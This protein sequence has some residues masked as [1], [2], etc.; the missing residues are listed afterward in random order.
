MV[1]GPLDCVQVPVPTEAAL[2]AVLATSDAQI[3]WSGPALACSASLMVASLYVEQV[4]L[5]IV[6]RMTYVPYAEA[7][8]VVVGSFTSPKVIVPGPLVC[9]QVP[10]PMVGVLA[11]VFT[12]RVAQ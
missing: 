5:V 8:A 9:D 3:S 2:A 4:P 7:V 6:H 10:V 11:R 1:P 12:T